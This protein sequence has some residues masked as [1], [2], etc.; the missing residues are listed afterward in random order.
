VI[1]R[2]LRDGLVYSVASVVI[3]ASGVIL[4]PLLT[5]RL[6]PA[7][8]GV[9]D[10]CQ[11]LATVAALLATGEI[12]QGLARYLHEAEGGRAA[13]CRTALTA[14]A[15]GAALG[16]AA[17]AVAAGPLAQLLTGSTAHSGAVRLAAQN[18]LL[19][20][21]FAALH[22]QLRWGL[23]PFAYL[24]VAVLLA[25]T[26]TVVTIT[27][28]KTGLGLHAALW[29]QAAGFA[30]GGI[31]AAVLVRHDFAGPFAWSWLRRML[32]FSAPLVVSSL[33]MIALTHANRQLL[34]WLIAL[35]EVGI[36]GA[37]WRITGLVTV[38]LGGFLGAVTPLIYAHYRQQGAPDQIVRMLGLFLATALTGWA[39]LCVLAPQVVGI[40][41]G[42]RFQ[43]ASGLV[44]ALVIA[45][46]WASLY[47][48]FPGLDITKRTWRIAAI[49][50]TAGLVNVGLC[51][52]LIPH[53]GMPGAAWATML[54]SMLHGLAYFRAGQ[55]GFPVRIPARLW[56]GLVAATAAAAVAGL[57]AA[58]D[59]LGH[60]PVASA[61]VGAAA[62]LGLALLV[63]PYRSAVR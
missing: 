6:G 3:G 37:A 19:G 26:T 14:T 15:V 10:L 22:R 47:V 40:L 36:Y 29:G 28:L 55:A 48:F 4:M 52:A 53:W 33:G 1:K 25:T 62:A 23:R 11:L 20:A 31:L 12:Q 60:R 8:Y 17:I 18:L 58:Q 61:A 42:S 39:L 57:P 45:A 44:P 59:L 56:I 2:F 49:N 63:W 51:L 34:G 41:A 13:L 30:A 54:S 27:L 24:A 35:T 50:V 5:R 46:I 38:C 9:L 43:P 16:C 21:L 32:A 7:D